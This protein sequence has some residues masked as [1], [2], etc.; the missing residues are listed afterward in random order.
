MSRRKKDPLRALSAE[1]R[2]EL[3]RLGRSGREPAAV[4]AHAKA[5]L[6]VG[7]GATYT[8]AATL[9]GRRSGD[10][11]AHLVARFNR[12][13]LEA[14]SPRHGG[15]P[16][17]RSTRVERERILSEA[18]RTPAHEPDQTPTWSLV[19]LQRARRR[20]PDGRP[21]V[22]TYTIWCVLTEADW[23]RTGGG[24]ELAA[25]AHLVPDRPCGAPAQ[26]W[27]GSHHRPGCRGERKL[28]EPAYREAEAGGV[29]VA[30]Q[31]EA[32]PSQTVPSPGSSWQPQAHPA[33]QPHEDLR[34]GTVKRLTQFR[35]ARGEGRGAS[36]R[37][38]ALP[39]YRPACRA[40]KRSGRPLGHPA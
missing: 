18:R 26:A 11:V 9:A 14:L 36:Q 40:Q 16:A 19:T 17:A 5:V 3:E 24:L 29:A 10:A 34:L 7:K 13:G 38:H 33:Q 22:S 1:E 8:Q 35:P 27:A 28:I 25:H 37:R 23:R 21:Q 6:A 15:G 32:G 12:D 39:Q 4:V 31:D 30:C 20:A 2:A